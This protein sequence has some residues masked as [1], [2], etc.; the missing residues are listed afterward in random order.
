MLDPMFIL[1]MV[2]LVGIVAG[3]LYAAYLI[4]NHEYYEGFRDGL[5]VTVLCFALFLAWIMN[6][7]AAT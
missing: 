2:G 7:G 6:S 1:G 3:P 5:I 4:K